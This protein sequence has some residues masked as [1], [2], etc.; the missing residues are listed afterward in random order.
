M[1]S[2]SESLEF[3]LTADFNCMFKVYKHV[4]NEKSNF[5]LHQINDA[6]ILKQLVNIK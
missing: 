6:G 5:V 4:I 1:S 3:I 2:S